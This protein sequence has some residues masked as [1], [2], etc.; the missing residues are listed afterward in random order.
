MIDSNYQD[1]YREYRHETKQN[2]KF[3]G[4]KENTVGG[5]AVTGAGGRR[6]RTTTF[7]S[8]LSFSQ[9]STHRSSN[10]RYDLRYTGSPPA[11]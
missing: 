6:T 1:A 3:T 9:T 4:I 8:C 11:Y 7:R 5:G 2:E 10:I